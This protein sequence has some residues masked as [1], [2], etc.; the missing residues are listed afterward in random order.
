MQAMDNQMAELN[1]MKVCLKAAESRKPEMKHWGFSFMADTE[2]NALRIAYAY[3]N[4]KHGVRIDHCPSVNQYM[5]TVWNAAAL[6]MGFTAKGRAS[7]EDRAP[8]PT[9]PTT[10]SGSI[11]DQPHP[12]P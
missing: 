10:P 8:E 11:N 4:N 1:V 3:R 7:S 2:L 12:H 5:V 9:I 6:E